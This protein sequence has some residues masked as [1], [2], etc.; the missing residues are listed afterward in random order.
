MRMPR[1][2]GNALFEFRATA[3][4]AGAGQSGV[5]AYALLRLTYVD[6]GATVEPREA[7][8][9]GAAAGLPA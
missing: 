9:N 2:G 5:S 1:S 3:S 7:S 8:A 6:A 4:A